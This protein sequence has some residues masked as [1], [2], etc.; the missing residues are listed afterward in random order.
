MLAPSKADC[1][2]VLA[3]ADRLRDPHA[4]LALHPGDFGLSR[5]SMETTARFLIERDCFVSYQKNAA[6]FTV[7][8]LSRQGRWRLE[9]LSDA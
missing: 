4:V 9:Q 6:G 7:G 1:I 3:A 8:A 2:T 5:N